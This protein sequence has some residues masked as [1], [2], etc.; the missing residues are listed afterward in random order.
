MDYESDDENECP[1]CRKNKIFTSLEC[2]HYICI[3]CCLQLCNPLC[4][5][6]RSSLKGSIISNDIIQKISE[7]QKKAKEKDQ[8]K[9]FSVLFFNQS[10][11]NTD[12]SDFLTEKFIEEFFYI[13]DIDKDNIYNFLTSYMEYIKN[14]CEIYNII[15]IEYNCIYSCNKLIEKYKSMYENVNLLINDFNKDILSYDKKILSMTHCKYVE[16]YFKGN[17]II[18]NKKK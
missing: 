2:G 10:I 14:S 16:E 8:L 18:E 7:N 9:N 3:T 4:P 5:F 12:I 17:I 11:D 13:F 15:Y 1:I 6:C